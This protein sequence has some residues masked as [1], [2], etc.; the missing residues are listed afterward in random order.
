MPSGGHARSGPAPDPSSFRS[1]AAGSSGGWTPMTAPPQAPPAWP[2]GAATQ[3]EATEW[4]ALWT[5]P[6]SS[7]W[8]R[9]GLVQDAA[10][11]V[12]T[13]LA[14]AASGYGNAALGGLMAR[15]AD[16]LG[17]T[18]A[19]AARNRWSWPTETTRGNRAALVPIQGRQRPSA[20][21]RFRNGYACPRTTSCVG[22]RTT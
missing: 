12:R 13:A 9:F 15:Q 14:F 21:D 8:E 6:A 7:L 18:V 19:G 3:A 11:Y 17:L 5:R 1:A 16:N 10:V 4:A 20:R 2:L 22:P